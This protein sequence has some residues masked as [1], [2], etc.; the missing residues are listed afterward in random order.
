MDIRLQS[1]GC[2]GWGHDLIAIGGA[3]Y[4]AGTSSTVDD[5]R[6]CI[7]LKTLNYGDYGI[8]LINYG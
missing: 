8:F 5:H 3:I 2:R 7:T 6:S 4:K 1:L